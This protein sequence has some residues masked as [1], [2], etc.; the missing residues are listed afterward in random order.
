MHVDGEPWEQAASE[1]LVRR[2]KAQV[3]MLAKHNRHLSGSSGADGRGEAGRRISVMIERPPLL[4]SP[5]GY[6]SLGLPCI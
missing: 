2:R 5:E 3:V 4:N 1:I 6:V